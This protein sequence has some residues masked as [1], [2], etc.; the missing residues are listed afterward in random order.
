[1][2]NEREE[3]F[4]P[5]RHPRSLR[6]P[7]R[8]GDNPDQSGELLTTSLDRNLQILKAKLG[9]SSDLVYR[10]FQIEV[11]NLPGALIYADGLIDGNLVNR[12]VLKAAMIDFDND[13]SQQETK[14]SRVLKT[15]KERGLAAA[16][17]KEEN[18]TQKLVLAV[19]SGDTVFLLEGENRA[20][21]INS[22]GWPQR[23][24]Q[25]P[26]T[27]TLI[28]GPREGFTETLRQ[29]TA[30]LRRRLRDPGLVIESLQVGRRSHTDLAVCYIKGIVSPK[31]LAEVKKRL[32][33]ID[34]DAVPESGYL[35]QLIED[36]YLSPFP[37]VQ[38]TERPDKAA[39]ALLEGRVALILD[40]TPFALLVPAT[41][42]MFFQSAED[43]YERWIV[44]SLLRF[45]RFA[46]SYIATFTPAIYVSLVS[47]N[48]NLIPSTLALSIAA[49]REGIPFPATVEALLMEVSFE[50]FRE[51]GA[52]LPKPIGQTLGVVGGLIVGEAAVNARL[53]SPAMLI[54]VALTSVAAFA[55][56]SYN[57][58]VGLR[59]VRFALL[60][61]GAVLGFYGIVLGFVIL[62]IHMVSMKSFGSTFL[63]PLAPYRFWDW[64]DTLFRAPIRTLA[65]R[66]LVTRPVDEVRQDEAGEERR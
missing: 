42:P 24:V 32:D 60:M 36:S 48:P 23:A 29:N 18:Q 65:T 17:V 34:I 53:V 5:M 3:F 49:S 39:A 63:S 9:P 38:N 15:V 47:Y 56:P 20:L 1:M 4:M 41:F 16:E 26:P 52:R 33:S 21:V 12:E 61:A 45:L 62:N 66:P 2:L 57:L 22:R 58:A 44:S 13:P 7:I 43:Y 8:P 64:K 50:I 40:G 54:V 51:A 55:I 59:T 35:E 28:R 19:L 10:I 6:K 25:E 11:V 30:L 27:E 14:S 37:Q 31:L 46:A